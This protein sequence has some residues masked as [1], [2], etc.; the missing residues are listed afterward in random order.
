MAALDRKTLA[1]LIGAPAAAA[2]IALTGGAEGERT[3]PYRDKLAGNIW[4]VCY[5]DTHVQMRKY[6]SAECKDLLATRLVD[7]A[8]PVRDMTPGFDDLTDGQ[9][10]AAIDFAYNAGIKNYQGSTLRKMYIAQDF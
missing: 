10:V 1:A 2:L 5:G 4:T 9:K 7:Y 8:T 6:S 3:E